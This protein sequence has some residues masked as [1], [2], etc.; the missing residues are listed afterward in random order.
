MTGTR[1]TP[2]PAEDAG[3]RRAAMPF[4]MVT[5]LID[6]VSIGLIVPVLPLLVGA[7]VVMLVAMVG[8]WRRYLLGPFGVVAAI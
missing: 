5:V 4:I 2:A 8:P 3:R 6:M 1:P 7:V